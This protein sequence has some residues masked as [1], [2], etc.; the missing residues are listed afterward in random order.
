MR[1][2]ASVTGTRCT[3]WTPRSNFSRLHAPRPWTNRITSLNPPTPVGLASITST[4]QRWRSAYFVYMRVRS[5]A[6]SAASSPPA[7]ARISTKKFFSSFGSPANRSRFSSSSSTVCLAVRSSISACASSA[8]SRSPPSARMWRASPMRRSR[9]RAVVKPATISRLSACSFRRRAYSAG[10]LKIA[11][12]DR[13][14]VISFDRSSIW[15]SLSNSIVTHRPP[16]GVGLDGQTKP[17][18]SATPPVSELELRGRRGLTLVFPLEALD[19]AGRVHEFVLAGVE[20]MALRAD[21]HVDVGPGG[22]GV[23]HLSARARD[24]RVHIVRMNTPLPSRPPL[25]P[26]KD[27]SPARLKLAHRVH[28]GEELLVGPG[29]LELVE[30]ELHPLHRVELGERLAEEPDLLELVLL[31]EKLFLPGARLLDVDGRED[32]LVHQPPVEMDFHVAGAFELLEDHVVHPASGVDD[33]RGHDRQRAA[34]LDVPGCREEPPRPLQRVG[35]ET[36]RQHLA[37][38][39]GDAGVG[40][41]EARQRV[42]QNDDVPLVLDQPLGLLDHHVGDLDVALRR[43][44]EGGRGHRPRRR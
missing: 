9:S 42:Q 13:R 21:L 10:W 22:T 23:N 3:R 36:A 1:P 41:R 18:A 40:A 29:E 32:A 27:T 7:P 35:V 14:R 6:N 19:P 31:E 2:E 15:R 26:T 38:R 25:K 34:L 16:G 11:G 12:S 30:Q 20:R 39:G 17:A 4:R 28:R 33:G 24:G 37:R 5:A 43:L 44:G 8:S